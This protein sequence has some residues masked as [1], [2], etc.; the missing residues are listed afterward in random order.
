MQQTRLNGRYE[1]LEKLGEGGVAIVYRAQDTLLDRIVA[2]KILR[3]QL[4]GDPTFLE[5]FRR[6]AQ[7]AARLS[8]PN[9]IGIYDVGQDGDQY[10]I[11]MEYVDGCDLKSFIAANAPLPVAQALSIAE[12]VCAA[13]D[14]AHKQGFV[15]RDIKPQNILVSSVAGR[16]TDSAP[17]VKVADFGLARSLTSLTSSQGGLVFGTVQYI[18]PEQ[19][20]GE[21]ATAA[22]DIYAL[23][24]VLYEMLTGRLPFESETPVGLALKHIQEEPLPPSRLNPRLPPTVD[25]FVLRA[26]AKQPEQRFASAGDM[27]TAL[28]SYRQFGEEATGQFRPVQA[29]ARPATP[30]VARPPAPLPPLAAQPAVRPVLAAHPAPR[31]QQQQGFDWLLLILFLVT[32]IAIAGLVPLAFAVRDTIFPSALPAA[33]QVKV[34]DLVGLEQVAAESQLQALG[35]VLVVQ[36]GRFDDKIAAQR[37]IAQLVPVGTSVDQGQHVEVIVSKGRETV[38]VPPVSGLALAEAQAR[39]SS[40][41]LR[42]DR[43]DMPSTQ[44]QAN[45][46]MAQ[47]PVAEVEVSRDALVHLTVSVGDRIVVPSL[48][49]KPE[50]DAQQM[51]RDAGL[52]TT[53]ANAQAAEDVPEQSRWVFSVVAVGGVISQSPEAGT[54]VERNTLVKLAVRKK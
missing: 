5:R 13:L 39:L 6:E 33:P 35:L 8:H 43:K 15:H 21:P 17:H 7:A 28:A 19:A 26:M 29:E 36:D 51:L 49:G 32:F 2:V 52:A 37:I 25:M 31:R 46:V 12:Q 40:V 9:I 30:G 10:Y 22:A 38:K 4:V 53:F 45:M 1:L 24:V 27:E 48:F 50:A 54:L 20:R 23:G 3:Q 44:V 11:V 14:H 41:G 16:G 34:P 47:D 42:S 18:A